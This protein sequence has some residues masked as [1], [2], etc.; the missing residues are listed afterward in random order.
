MAHAQQHCAL[1][2]PTCMRLRLVLG[3]VARQVLPL[4]AQEVHQPLRVQHM[5]FTRGRACRGGHAGTQTQSTSWVAPTNGSDK[6]PPKRRQHRICAWGSASARLVVKL[7]ACTPAAAAA[8]ALG[9]GWEKQQA[10]VRAPH[11]SSTP[12][13]LTGTAILFVLS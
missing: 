5:H 4:L 3:G 2:P 6:V 11:K 13:D 1:A 12:A 8:H 9:D 10:G 7:Q